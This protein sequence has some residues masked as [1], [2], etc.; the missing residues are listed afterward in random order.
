M[1]LSACGGFRE[2]R[3]N[4][5]NWFGASQPRAAAP[6]AAER[7]VDPRPLVDQVI[8][9]AIEPMPGG[10]ILR[11]TGLPPTQGYWMAELV[12][13]RGGAEDPV[14][15]GVLIFDFRVA[16]PPPDAA[17]AGQ[18]A[19]REIEAAIFLSDND[20]AGIRTIVVRGA[21]TERVLRR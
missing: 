19:S 12:H 21:R 4:P 8:A 17:L 15:G 20:L 3:Y 9:M 6:A 18:P 1:A 2:S 7:P 14:A 16:P 10:A 11:A 13:H 5:L